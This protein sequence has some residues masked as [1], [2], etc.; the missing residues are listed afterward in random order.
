MGLRACDAIRDTE[1]A[2]AVLTPRMVLSWA[3]LRS[4]SWN[5]WYGDS[6]WDYAFV[7]RRYY[8][9]LCVVSY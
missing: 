5:V 1:T 9:V 2:H 6:I 8:A 7:L 4:V 3:A